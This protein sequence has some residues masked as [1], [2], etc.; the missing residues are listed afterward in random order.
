MN[1]A[2]QNSH[3]AFLSWRDISV[4]NR[5]RRMFKLQQLVVDNTVSDEFPLKLLLACFGKD[6]L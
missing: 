2:A 5:A 3:E 1:Y 6:H 4:S